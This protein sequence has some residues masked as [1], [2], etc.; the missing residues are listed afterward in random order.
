MSDHALLSPSGATRWM[1]CP[2]SARLEE[3]FEDSGSDFAREGTLDHA[4]GELGLKVFLNSVG[5]DLIKAE[6]YLR[7]EKALKIDP[8]YNATMQ[9]YVDEYVAYVI[10]EYEKIKTEDN[11]AVIFI[12][13]KLDLRMYIP[14]SFG[15]GDAI[16]ISKNR[17]KIIDLKYGQGVRVSCEKNKQMMLYGL[18]AFKDFE[19][20]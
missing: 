6:E 9:D 5:E 3:F 17:L 19:F 10:A 18:G 7:E 2:P 12:E 8:M 16:I 4:L 14:E 1:A 15:T 13:R 20:M 11:G